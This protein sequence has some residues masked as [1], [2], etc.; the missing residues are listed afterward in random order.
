[1]AGFYHYTSK[2]VV[3]AMRGRL[4]ETPMGGGRFRRNRHDI[5][6][7]APCVLYYPGQSACCEKG[8]G[9]SDSVGKAGEEKNPS[10]EEFRTGAV[11]S[12]AGS[13][14][15]KAMSLPKGYPRTSRRSSIQLQSL[16]GGI[17]P[18]GNQPCIRAI[19]SV[20]DSV[21]GRLVAEKDDCEQDS[22]AEGNEYGDIGMI[23]EL[24]VSRPGCR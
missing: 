16:S 6:P 20:S 14:G 17:S 19:L 8:C 11:R 9:G 1:M 7:V 23:P 12:V 4:G 15:L 3:S 13:T 24:T 10:L 5:L 21:L 18:N 2:R 22:Q